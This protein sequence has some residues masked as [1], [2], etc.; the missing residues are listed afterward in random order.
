MR[1]PSIQTLMRLPATNNPSNPLTLTREQAKAVRY[2]ID[3]H[4]GL[5]VYK[6]IINAVSLD[7]I[8]LPDGCENN[9]QPPDVMIHYVNR[10]DTYA[11]T[12]CKVNYQY[13][14][15]SWGDEVERL[16]RTTVSA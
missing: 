15:T 16:T 5:L 9:C 14:V 1:Q 8:C 6:R 7:R 12:L 10:G 13:K 3:R 2:G 11:V 4:V